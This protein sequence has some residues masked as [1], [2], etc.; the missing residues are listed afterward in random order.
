MRQ[1]II[2]TTFQTLTNEFP[3]DEI[4]MRKKKSE[5]KKKKSKQ[6]TLDHFIVDD[7]SDEGM[8]KKK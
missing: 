5:K 7:S 8:S 3:A 2:I 1:Q 4:D 6:G